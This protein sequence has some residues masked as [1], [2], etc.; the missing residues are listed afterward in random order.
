MLEA[1]RTEG[2]YI[3]TR[4]IG[5]KGGSKFKTTRRELTKVQY[6]HDYLVHYT[7]SRLGALLDL[8]YNEL[9]GILKEARAIRKGESDDSK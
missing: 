1:V 6:D 7:V 9:Q 2:F 8:P 4:N 5:V 3:V